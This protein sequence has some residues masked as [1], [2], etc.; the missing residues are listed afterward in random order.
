MPSTPGLFFICNQE[1]KITNVIFNDVLPYEINGINF[2]DL[3]IPDDRIKAQ[4]FVASIAAE[5][6]KFNWDLSVQIGDEVKTMIFSGT[7]HQDELV[8]VG[9]FDNQVV[10]TILDELMQINNEQINQYRASMKAMMDANKHNT[11]ETQNTLDELTRLNNEM[12][13]LQRQ[14]TKQNVELQ[15][16]NDLKNQFLGMAA[17]DLRNPLANIL[18]FAQFLQADQDQF[19][20]EQKEF[21]EYIHSIAKNMVELVNNLLDV[22]A[23]E[24]GTVTLRRGLV[25]LPDLAQETIKLQQRS[26]EEKDIRIHFKTP[27]AQTEVIADEAKLGQVIDN[28]LSNAIK[29]SQP[30]SSV[31]LQIKYNQNDLVFS[32]SDQGQGIAQNELD[33][34]FK[35]FQ[36]TSART[37]GGEKSTG[38]GLYICKRIIDAHGGR[39]WADSKLGSGSTFYF[40]LPLNN[41]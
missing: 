17:H 20:D 38:L 29:Y 5:K 10:A 6:S 35:P 36:R 7:Q 22:S 16:L 19:N 23:I 25:C 18:N 28:F 9:G 3:T 12:A 14:V 30:G 39:I 8:F 24:S 4:Q 40:S 32:V 27:A 26:A 34:L 11:A 37:T 15:K 33:R 2:L 1:F 13:N 31:T 41:L 21:I